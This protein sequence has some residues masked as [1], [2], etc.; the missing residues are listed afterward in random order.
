VQDDAKILRF[1]NSKDAARLAELG[2]SCPDHFLRTKIKP[3][4]V[5]WNPQAEDVAALKQKLAAGLD[6]TART[7]PP[8]TQAANTPT[9]RPCATPTR[10]SC[11]SP[12]SA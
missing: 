3:L 2:T 11:S 5:D 10:P 9:R 6:S 8:T 1:V 4:Y 12:A 7:T